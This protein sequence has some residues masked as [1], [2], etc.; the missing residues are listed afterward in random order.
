MG[1]GMCE[2][3][4]YNPHHSTPQTGKK[5]SLVTVIIVFDAKSF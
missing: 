1:V 4:V 2:R 3:V 5:V